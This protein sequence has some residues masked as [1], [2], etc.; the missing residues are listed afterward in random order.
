VNGL[1][2]LVA[3]CSHAATLRVSADGGLLLGLMAAGATGSAFHCGP[4]CGPFVLG[5]VA[6]RMSRVPAVRLCEWR[7]LGAGALLPYHLGRMVTYTALGAGAAASA[8]VL[9]RAP[10]FGALSV[11]LLLTAAALF[12]L[13][14]LR[15]IAPAMTLP[16]L[17][18]APAGWSQTLFRL[19]QRFGGG[20][21]SSGFALGLTLGFLPCGF[22]YA[23]LMA[24]ASTL[25]PIR[26]AAAMASFALGT[27][28]GL[29]VVGIAGQVAGRHWQRAIAWL[30]PAVLTANALMLVVLAWRAA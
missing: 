13:Q 18:R 3:F 30:S 8:A 28:P 1:D 23:A 7:R 4:M 29:M 22:L 11:V 14:A 12:L 17:D 20:S 15:R 25:D 9:G 21:G 16:A 19:A 27:M 2:T 24:A 26:G 5:Q 6:D 10:W